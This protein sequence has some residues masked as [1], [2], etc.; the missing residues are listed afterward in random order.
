MVR[1]KD[2]KTWCETKDDDDVV[3]LC[4]YSYHSEAYNR[5][6]SGELY[7]R[8]PQKRDFKHEECKHYE[9]VDVKGELRRFCNRK[10]EFFNEYYSY[11]ACREFESDKEINYCRECKDC[12]KTYRRCPY[13]KNDELLYVGDGQVYKE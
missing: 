10:N 1:I 12:H 5:P 3:F 9:I 4:E 2:L 8:P 7:V 13:V 11:N 6:T